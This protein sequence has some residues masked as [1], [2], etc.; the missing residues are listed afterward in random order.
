MKLFSFW[1]TFKDANLISFN[2]LA[3]IHFL[4]VWED[5]QNKPQ[6]PLKEKALFEYNSE[7]YYIIGWKIDFQ[8]SICQCHFRSVNTAMHVNGKLNQTN[9][10][11]ITF[12]LFE[13]NSSSSLQTFPSCE[14]LK[15]FRLWYRKHTVVEIH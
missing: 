8:N 10:F 11:I 9:T 4:L 14:H 2:M 5:K 3:F 6:L 15:L 13:S 12:S 7:L 1:Q